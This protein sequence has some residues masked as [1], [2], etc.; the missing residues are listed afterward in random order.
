MAVLGERVEDGVGGGVVGLARGAEDTGDGGEQHEGVQVTARGQ[1]VQVQGRVRLRPQ[2]GIQPLARQ[3]LHRAVVQDAGEME[4]GTER[5]VG[6]NRVEHPGE[7]GAVGRVTGR[8]LHRPA[9]PGQLVREFGRPGRGGAAP[10]EQQQMPDPVPRDQMPHQESPQ[11]AQGTGDQHG[12]VTP[13]RPAA[14][15]GG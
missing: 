7:R 15:P 12:P 10:A 1:L 4:H 13:P 6:G 2:Y 9:R 11:T 14:A 8:E 5:P 3:R